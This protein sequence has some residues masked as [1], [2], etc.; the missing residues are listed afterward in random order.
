MG[1]FDNDS[2]AEHKKENDRKDDDLMS[3]LEEAIHK[4]ET[5]F[6]HGKELLHNLSRYL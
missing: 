2:I 1:S 3:K 6:E 5:V 4:G